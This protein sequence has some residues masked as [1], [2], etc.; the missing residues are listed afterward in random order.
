M[1][2]E[3]KVLWE[4]YTKDVTPLG[5]PKPPEP[6]PPMPVR[7]QFPSHKLDLHGLTLDEAYSATNDFLIEAVHEYK[8]VTVVTGV[9]GDIKREFPF[10][11]DK[12]HPLVNRI[13]ELNGGG[14]YRVYFKKR[15]KLND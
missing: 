9:S 6:P 1:S 12:Q 3:D 15:K 2:K 13:E 7:F 4:D 10:W 11:F 8:S 5:A 14:A